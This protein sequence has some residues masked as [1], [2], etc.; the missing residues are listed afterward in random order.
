MLQLSLR[1]LVQGHMFLYRIPTRFGVRQLTFSRGGAQSVEN[2]NFYLSLACV[3]AGCVHYA[4]SCMYSLTAFST[5]QL[6]PTSTHGPPL[7][8]FLDRGFGCSWTKSVSPSNGSSLDP[9]ESSASWAWIMQSRQSSDCPWSIY[10]ISSSMDTVFVQLDIFQVHSSPGS[11][12][13]SITSSFSEEKS[14]SM[15]I[16]FTRNTVYHPM[17]WAERRSYRSTCTRD[18]RRCLPWSSIRSMGRPQRD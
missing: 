3:A 4:G 1:T 2:F 10:V 11:L 15:S 12:E 18:N 7:K 16:N 5:T 6:P 14:P 13:H 8:L 9:K 17:T